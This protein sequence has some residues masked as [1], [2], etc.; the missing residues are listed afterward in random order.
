MTSFTLTSNDE[1]DV[2]HQAFSVLALLELEG[3]GPRARGG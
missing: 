2:F 3:R 1:I